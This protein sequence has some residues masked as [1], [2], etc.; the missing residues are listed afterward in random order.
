MESLE[1]AK[2]TAEQLAALSGDRVNELAN[3]LKSVLVYP[4]ISSGQ[5]IAYIRLQQGTVIFRT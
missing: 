2:K 1:M 3:E 4:L 5:Y